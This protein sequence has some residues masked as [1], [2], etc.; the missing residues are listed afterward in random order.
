MGKIYPNSEKYIIRILVEVDRKVNKDDI[1]GAIFGQTEGLISADM[2][3]RELQ[4]RGEIGRIEPEGELTYHGDKTI[5]V[6][7]LASNTTLERTVIIAAAIETV[8]KV[9]SSKASFKVDKIIDVREEKKNKIKTRAK[10]L[11]K[12]FSE[13]FF[14][15][16]IELEKELRNER[17]DKEIIQLVPDNDK[18]VAHKNYDVYDEIIL[19]EGK[20][21]VQRLLQY[22]IKNVIS[23]GGVSDQIPKKIIDIS[24][25]KTTILFVDGDNGGKNVAKLLVEKGVKIDYIARAPEGK[26]VEELSKKEI[27]TALKRKRAFTSESELDKLL[28]AISKEDSNSKDEEVEETQEQPV[29]QEPNHSSFLTPL[30]GSKKCTLLYKDMSSDTFP[31]N[32]IIQKLKEKPNDILGVY[33]DGIISE[34][35]FKAL[36]GVSFKYLG[37]TNPN[38]K[39]KLS[40]ELS[41]KYKIKD[42]KVVSIDD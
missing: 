6:F 4:S 36:G 8:D 17:L 41:S 24:K 12:Q 22:D 26:E 18:V 14:L 32:L 27:N 9:G 28:E 29:E 33:I 30:V 13:E 40:T 21:D 20:A 38:A 31:I 2:N 10:E 11:I 37:T 15:D 3:L 23:V 5:A 16:I 19:V 35:V 42:V 1:I 7:R 25:S 34:P 39:Y